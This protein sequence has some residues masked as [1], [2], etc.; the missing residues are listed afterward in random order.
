MYQIYSGTHRTLILY[1]TTIPKLCILAFW[2]LHLQGILSNYSLILFSLLSGFIG[3]TAF[4]Q[5]NLRFL[6]VYS[7]ISE[8]G[9]LV[10][11]LETAGYNALIQ[12][13]SVY[14]ISQF[15]LWNINSTGPQNNR[16]FPFLAISLAGMPPLAGFF[17]KA[18]IFW[19]L[20]TYNGVT[21]LV[22]A[23]LF[24]FVSIV[25]YLRLLR[26]S[27][28]TT[29]KG[30]KTLPSSGMF[31]IASRGASSVLPTGTVYTAGKNAG[32]NNPS[33]YGVR[34]ADSLSSASNIDVHVYSPQGSNI[35]TRVY[36]TS[37]C[38]VLLVIL[39]IFLMKPFF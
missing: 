15:L 31:I 30:N 18:W 10:A 20:S 16:I 37:T 13:L 39:P 6:L 17:G 11:A 29:P 2:M 28:Y 27:W 7:S 1:I 8:M 12:H 23:L 3:S 24:A 5:P 36:L 4:T 38:V 9:L 26:L 25:F 22:F 14:I 33:N 21:L 32:L 34:G 19:H 35:P